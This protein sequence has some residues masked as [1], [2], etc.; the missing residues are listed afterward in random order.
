MPTAPAGGMNQCCG[1][2]R[3]TDL[4][5]LPG[6]AWSWAA[7]L[8]SG[9]EV[10]SHDLDDAVRYSARASSPEKTHGRL[11]RILDRRRPAAPGCYSRL[12]R[13]PSE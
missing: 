7:G 13:A 10:R 5:V 11:R 2:G 6:F 4:A 9:G 3:F 12:A 1:R 8:N